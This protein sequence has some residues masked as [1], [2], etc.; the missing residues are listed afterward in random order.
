MRPASHWRNK[1]THEAKS[2]PVITPR[3]K[4]KLNFQRNSAPNRSAIAVRTMASQTI[5]Q[6]K[7][8]PQI[9]KNHPRQPA[10]FRTNRKWA[11]IASITVSLWSAREIWTEQNAMIKM[12]ISTLAIGR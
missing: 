5:M 3:R 1:Q 8:M 4:A 2:Q 9:T 12:L 10:F 6:K 11:G 7:W